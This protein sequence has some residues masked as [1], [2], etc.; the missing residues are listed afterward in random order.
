MSTAER[1]G[2]AVAILIGVLVRV[3]PIVGA[4]SVVG[5]GGLI[6]ALV[7]DIRAAGL[8]LPT[9]ASYN[10]LGIPFVYPP[11]AIWLAAAVGAATG[12][13]SLDVLTWMPMAVAVLVLTAFAWLSVRLLPPMAAV[14]ATFAFALMPSA[15]GWLVAG[16]GLTRGS[17][18]LFALMAAA[19]AVGPSGAAPSLRRA[20]L[21]GACLGL[22]G[23]TH[24]QGI[25][26]GVVA[27]GALTFQRPFADWGRHAAIAA[28][29]AVVVLLPWLAWVVATNGLESI[30]SAGSRFEPVTGLIRLLN[31]RF[32]GVL[33]MDL[34]GV[35]GVIGLVVQVIRRQWRVPALLLL[36][37]LVGAGG[38]EFLAAAPWALLAGAGVEAVVRVWRSPGAP[39]DTRL[40]RRAVAATAAVAL[41]LSLIGA[42]GSVVDSASKLHPLGDA[43]IAAMRWLGE[44]GPDVPVLVPTNEVWGFDDVSE[45]LPAIADRHSMG[46]VQGSEW[47]G[48]EGFDAQIAIHE[49]IRGC[50]GST[51]ACYRSLAPDAV[52]FIPK[53]RLAGLFSPS[54][55]CPALREAVEAAGY[56]IVYDGPGAT[57]AIPGGAQEGG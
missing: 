57:I 19:I 13:A 27:C 12:S 10:D 2:I 35:A 1:F 22:A 29:A 40:G 45:W 39:G 34:V 30:L 28:A 11:A 54:D 3:A 46:T 43:T 36:V 7:D 4:G 44:N 37:S 53:G 18:L 42:L 5:D 14:S 31:L 25:V 51:A 49:S 26:F 41:F 24:P 50:A 15:Y 33:F 23:L 55:C 17:G 16:G 56:R 20:V 32:S 6:L 9:T 38:G 47:L 8:R 21:T 48:S 52:L